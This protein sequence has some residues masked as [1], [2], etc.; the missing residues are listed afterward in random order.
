MKVRAKKKLFYHEEIYK[1]GEEFDLIPKTGIEVTFTKHKDEDTKKVTFEKT[2]TERSWTPEEQF[3]PRVHVKVVAKK[4][5]EVTEDVEPAKEVKEV[6]EVKEDKKGKRPP[7]P[8]D[9]EV[10]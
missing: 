3:N 7:R 2:E 8:Q 1:P 4:Y 9:A 6:K 5:V 10:A